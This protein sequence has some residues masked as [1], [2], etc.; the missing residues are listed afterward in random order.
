M[1]VE[2]DIKTIT[3]PKFPM[4][5]LMGGGVGVVKNRCNASTGGKGVGRRELGGVAICV[6]IVAIIISHVYA[7]TQTKESG[8]LCSCVDAPKLPI[9]FESTHL[10]RWTS[11][12]TILNL[13]H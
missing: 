5:R 9:Q 3:P 2:A 11:L 8:P 6:G 4:V 12:G 7:L 1:V 13:E 10:H